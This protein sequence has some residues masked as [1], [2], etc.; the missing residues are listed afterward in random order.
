MLTAGVLGLSAACA[1]AGARATEGT[2]Q[3]SAGPSDAPAA[4]VA[5]PAATS[6]AAVVAEP[7]PPATDSAAATARQ[8]PMQALNQMVT[9]QALLV[10]L[11]LA[12]L[13][14]GAAEAPLARV[15][16]APAGTPT[17]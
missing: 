6:R 12:P 1:G 13:S 7:R 11:L 4:V 8:S 16:A 2:L 14:K 10:S 17:R 3:S 9:A 5:L 15:D